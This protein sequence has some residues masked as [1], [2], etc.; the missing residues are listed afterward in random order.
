M[1]KKKLIK[2]LSV[3]MAA[4]MIVTSGVPISVMASV[5][6]SADHI[7]T[8]SEDYMS[9]DNGHWKS[10]TCGCIT[11]EDITQ[12]PTYAEHDWD[13]DNAIVVQPTATSHGYTLATCKE[14]GREKIINEISHTGEHH[15]VKGARTLEK[16][17]FY[18]SYSCDIDNCTETKKEKASDIL[19]AVAKL[20]Y[21]HRDEEW[22]NNL[23]LEFGYDTTN[24]PDVNFDGMYY[25]IYTDGILTKSDYIANGFSIMGATPRSD[26]EA[27]FTTILGKEGEK[28]EYRLV[29]YPV[30]KDT[31]NG[32]YRACGEVENYKVDQSYVINSEEN[33]IWETKYDND[34][35]W[36]EAICHPGVIKNKEKHNWVKLVNSSTEPTC[37]TS[38]HY[39]YECSDCNAT[40]EEE[41]T[42]LDHNWVMDSRTDGYKTE[43]CSYCGTT[44]CIEN[45]TPSAWQVVEEATDSKN[46]T[47]IKYCLACGK[48]LET[49]TYTK[50]DEDKPQPDQDPIIT[51]GCGNVTKALGDEAFYLDA[52]VNNSAKIK[53]EVGDDTVAT[54]D[55][56]GL[57]TIIGEGTTRIYAE[58]DAV[59]GWNPTAA[60]ITLTVTA[61]RHNHV[62][63]T[64]WTTNKT[65]HWH[66]CTADGCDGTISDKAEHTVSD[67]IIDKEAT[68]TSTG[69]KHKECTVCGYITETEEIPVVK[70]NHTH[71]WSDD[72]TYDTDYHWHGCI[73]DDCDGSVNDK[74]EH[75]PSDWIVDKV[76]TDTEKGSRHKECVVCGYIMTTEDIPT[77]T[78][79][80]PSHTHKFSDEWTSDNTSHWHGCIENDCDGT[81]IDKANHTASDWI[82]DK[83]A[84][85]TST[86]SKHK[87]C[88]VCGYVLETEEIP[89]IK[90]IHNWSDKWSSDDTYHWH[91]CTDSNCDEI[92]DKE[93]HT[94]VT[95]VEG[96]RGKYTDGHVITKCSICGKVLNDR[97]VS[98]FFTEAHY[99][100][101][102]ADIENAEK[103]GTS[104]DLNYG[105]FE[106]TDVIP[107]E[108]L[109]LIQGHDV[110]VEL[111]FDTDTVSS[112]DVLENCV[113]I[114]FNG[115][116]V[117]NPK[118]IYPGFKIAKAVNFNDIKDKIDDTLQDVLGDVIT[119]ANAF[120]Y[121]VLLSAL[122][123]SRLLYFKVQNDT[124]YDFPIE[125]ELRY[126]R[127]DTSKY[128][129]LYHID[130]NGKLEF[131]KEIT[132]DGTDTLFDL[133]NT[134]NYIAISS[135]T[136]IKDA[137]IDVKPD[138]KKDDNNAS[139]NNNNNS[140]NIT[141]S[142][143]ANNNTT[144]GSNTDTNVDSNTSNIDAT[145]SVKTGDN[146]N[147]WVPIVITLIGFGA[148][149][150]SLKKKHNIVK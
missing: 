71:K 123:P 84:T 62:F 76:A 142:N 6:Q 37:Q 9:N 133:S 99:K 139:N 39:E 86:G 35:H 60:N 15:W 43:T 88:T 138:N 129:S 38:G 64:E 114:S 103:E 16:G 65:F 50:D 67:W 51:I 113:N 22:T 92:N 82:I 41:I 57:V 83:E 132:K 122:K 117:K 5:N 108:F 56:N 109:E 10:F 90:P 124:N 29:M 134:G 32:G 116:D 93:E 146:N 148:I 45:H 149:V 54:V 91:D 85:T 120:D 3:L 97:V 147:V 25:E 141:T 24:Y 96:Q 52:S 140:G 104:V 21:S 110:N 98:G 13:M 40:K 118:D 44:R 20:N 68:T 31:T 17:V 127:N 23:E 126:F 115:K 48:I 70:P 74:T 130:E 112:S 2:G 46:G 75:I 53:Y 36:L 18:D 145:K 136:S 33:H 87:E 61:Q 63:D 72:W 12:N 14:C 19:P 28:H 80:K 1:I 78:P 7:H 95:V 73:A 101:I 107:K 77:T 143:D 94:L 119:E 4:T 30:V 111:C 8:Y 49:S 26:K 11:E 150:L 79:V 121:V 131:V 81:V 102:K 100:E 137:K 135:D 27:I 105:A 106:K 125:Y 58:V 128:I 69:S 47:K 55:E 42:P 34:Y 144:F 89:T 59:D 66:K